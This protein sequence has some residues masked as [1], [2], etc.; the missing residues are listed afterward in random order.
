M[1]DQPKQDGDELGELSS[2]PGEMFRVQL[3]GFEGPLDLLLHLIKEHKLDIFDIPIALITEKYLATLDLM[4]KLNLDVAG[5]FILMAATLAHLKS[6]LLLPSVQSQG[7]D[8]VEEEAGDP[9]EELVRRLLDYQKYKAAGEDLGQQ[10]L[11]ERDVFPRRAPP[12]E[13]PPPESVEGLVEISVFKLIEAFSEVMAKAKV[14]IPHEVLVERTS[15][16]DAIAQLAEKLRETAQINF[17]KL[18]EGQVEKSRLVVTFL[19][20][21]EMTRLKLIKL[22][23]EEPTGD[24]VIRTAS[25]KPLDVA[26]EVN[27]EYA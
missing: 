21:L 23:Q 20:L 8:A 26:P 25:G 4:R 10:E 9:R 2:T 27:D 1:A 24:I 16:S 19:A 5:E 7:P 14:E 18:F 15:I 3:P 12:E 11:L 22:F 13:P 17:F 6:R